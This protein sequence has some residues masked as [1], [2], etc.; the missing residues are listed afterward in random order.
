MEVKRTP[1][2]NNFFIY[3]MLK[4]INKKRGWEV[5][6]HI[7][8]WCELKLCWYYLKRNAIYFGSILL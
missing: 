7:L 4:K 5:V 1:A 2:Y 8:N 6:F 3:G